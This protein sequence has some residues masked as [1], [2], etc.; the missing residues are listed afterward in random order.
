MSKVQ[1]NK[2]HNTAARGCTRQALR[3]DTTAPCAC[4]A[5]DKASEAD[6]AGL[7]G[8]VKKLLECRGFMWDVLMEGEWTGCSRTILRELT[9]A[10]GPEAML[11]AFEEE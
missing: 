8:Q 4:A 9:A 2:D 10:Y 11:K 6:E 1:T 5:L 7:Q 3:C